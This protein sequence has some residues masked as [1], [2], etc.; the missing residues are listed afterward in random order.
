MQTPSKLWLGQE[1]QALKLVP[2]KDLELLIDIID[3]RNLRPKESIWVIGGTSESE[4]IYDNSSITEVSLR[5]G[6]RAML[7]MVKAIAPHVQIYQQS[8]SPH[9]FLAPFWFCRLPSDTVSCSELL[10]CTRQPEM[11]SLSSNLKLLSHTT[12]QPAIDYHAL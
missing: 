8:C 5:P 12:K 3:T 6:L 9:D 10:L 2:A 11:F 7:V 1:I 4:F